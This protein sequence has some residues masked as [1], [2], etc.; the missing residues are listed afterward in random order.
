MRKTA[1]CTA[2]TLFALVALAHLVRYLLAVE[3]TIGG[4]VVPVFPSLPIAIVLA[5]L[6]G[7]M[8]IEARRA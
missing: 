3:V 5:A 2:G 7:W 4:T 1:L 8:F 6:A